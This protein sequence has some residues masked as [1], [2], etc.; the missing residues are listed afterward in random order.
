MQQETFLRDLRD[1][2]SGR[3]FIDHKR[4]TPIMD[5]NII[6]VLQKAP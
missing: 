2:R 6:G 5:T 1:Q 4:Y 3:A